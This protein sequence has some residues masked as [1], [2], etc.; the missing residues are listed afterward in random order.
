ML[1]TLLHHGLRRAELCA[2]HLV[3]LPKR[4]GV[5]HQRVLGVGIDIGIDGFGPHALRAT[6]ILNALEHDA[7]LEKVQ[8]CV[9]HANVATTRMHDHRKHRAEDTVGILGIPSIPSR[10]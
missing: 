8:H 10:P 9:G 5:R 1:T 4:R 6:A 3:D 2:L 7:D